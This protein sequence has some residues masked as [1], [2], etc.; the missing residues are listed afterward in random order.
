MPFVGNEIRLE[1][2]IY[3]KIWAIYGNCSD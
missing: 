3:P 2:T 1:P